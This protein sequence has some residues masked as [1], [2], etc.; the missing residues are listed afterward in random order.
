MLVFDNRALL[1]SFIRLN[2][3]RLKPSP[4]H[5]SRGS[6]TFEQAN[7][8]DKWCKSERLFTEKLNNFSFII[9]ADRKEGAHDNDTIMFT[10][11][12]IYF[13]ICFKI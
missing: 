5:Y 9:E 2:Q 4:A 13:Y 3:I 1:F 12:D 7:T 8:R 11:Y 6:W 10:I